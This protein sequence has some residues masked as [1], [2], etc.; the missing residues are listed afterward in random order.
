MAA[1]FSDSSKQQMTRPNEDKNKHK[2]HKK[3]TANNLLALEL[4]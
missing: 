4:H 2:E 3:D 1:G